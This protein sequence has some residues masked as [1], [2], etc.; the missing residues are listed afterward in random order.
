[1]RAGSTQTLLTPFHHHYWYLPTYPPCL[2]TCQ[3]QGGALAPCTAL[4][5][6]E[7]EKT[8]SPF[9]QQRAVSSKLPVPQS[10]DIGSAWLFI[11]LIVPCKPKIAQPE[12][13]MVG[14]EQVGELQISVHH[15]MRVEPSHSFQQLC[16]P[17]A[18]ARHL[19]CYTCVW[20]HRQVCT[21]QAGPCLFHETLDFC[22][23]ERR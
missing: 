8:P 16:M 17:N 10:D 14:H 22:F 12:M 19:A 9:K 21:G 3:I 18:S 11:G 15:P 7:L 1:M 23:C 2:C 5:C 6:K 20:V 4:L 13:T